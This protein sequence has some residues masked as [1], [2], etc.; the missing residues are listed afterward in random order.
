M[1]GTGKPRFDQ[2][3]LVVRDMKAMVAFYAHLGVEVEDMPAPWDE[4]H[5]E[6]GHHTVSLELDSAASATSWNQGWNASGTGPILSFRV[7]DRAEVDRLCDVLVEAGATVMQP[8]YD[9]FWG[10]RYAILRDPDGN[11]VGI[12]TEPDPA[13][14]TP[15]PDPSRSAGP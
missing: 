15:P 6:A 9:T 11:A 2:I 8:A 12:M 7:D 14:R 13:R 5:R 1:A 4:H 10:S 3:N